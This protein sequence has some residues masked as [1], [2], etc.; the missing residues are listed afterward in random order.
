MTHFLQKTFAPTIQLSNDGGSMR[1][2]KVMIALLLSLVPT[3]TD[4]S[5]QSV[6]I[7][8]VSANSIG[9]ELPFRIF[10]NGGGW[11][12]EAGAEYV[13]VH[14]FPDKEAALGS[15][16]VEFCS[17][18]PEPF[19]TY[20]NFDEMFMGQNQEDAYVDYGSS[21][22]LS[23]QKAGLVRKVV[24]GNPLVRSI[25][26]NFQ[27]NKDLCLERLSLLDVNGKAV[28]VQT[29]RV[30][31]G[32]AVASS[33]LSPALSYGVMNLFDSRFEYA[34]ASHKQSTGVELTFS[35]LKE[36]TV[37]KIMIWNGYQRSDVHCQANSRV[38]KLRVTGDGGYDFVIPVADQM[39]SQMLDLPRP[40]RGKMLKLSV[41][42][43]YEGKAY[44]DL[45]ISELRFFDGAKWF[46]LNPLTSIQAIST[47]H[48]KEFGK[49]SL[50]EIL[51]KDLETD[52]DFGWTLRLRAD[53]SVYLDGSE[54]AGSKGSDMRRFVSGL[55]NYEVLSSDQ[56][57]GVRLR[58]FGFLRESI[59]KVEFDC[60]G[61]GRD[62]NTT[63]RDPKIKERIFQQ[64]IALKRI[65]E[66]GV[67][68]TNEG[69]GGKL[70]F[71]SVELRR[72]E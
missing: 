44:Q 6:A 13:K 4:A 10:E 26:L 72:Y 37:E 35:F 18:K 41:A 12:P 30:V 14:I 32:T 39:G 58:V 9:Q 60:N 71:K 51:N 43:A 34:W 23:E 25:T 36:E 48:R 42:E 5:S 50:T 67:L 3:V 7:S 53:G 27:R 56:K 1:S 68:M 16:E 38:K 62:C 54:K 31:E 21:V 15:L 11:R 28:V 52:Y 65:D 70:G 45:V 63:K 64:V 59:Q 49:S 40:F 46:L 20:V 29:P 33:T 17:A 19:A 66:A 22:G 61:C 47:Q 55:G 2:V 69:G 57:Q 8:M 24:L